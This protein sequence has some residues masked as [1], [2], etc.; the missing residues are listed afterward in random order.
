MKIYYTPDSFG[1]NKL[2]Q[3]SVDAHILCAH[4]LGGE[5][6]DFFDRTRGSF[7]ETNIQ[8]PFVHVNG[9]HTSNNLI[10]RRFTFSFS[11]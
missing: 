10:N 1:P 9:I 3:S 6:A 8:K 7:L 4:L 2:V 5:F 11:S